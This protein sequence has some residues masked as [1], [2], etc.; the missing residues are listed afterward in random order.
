MEPATSI[1]DDASDLGSDYPRNWNWDVDGDEIEGAFVE[2]DEAPT[3]YGSRPIVVLDVAGEKRT[4]WLLETALRSSFADEASRR[5]SS[6]GFTVGERIIVRRGAMRQSS[7]G[8]SYRSFKA[9]F[10]DR[11][12]RSAAQILGPATLELATSPADD[13]IPY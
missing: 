7:T 6:D 5:S 12:K 2:L 3:A 9:L 11:P 10:L 13:G 4:L 1:Y 8:R